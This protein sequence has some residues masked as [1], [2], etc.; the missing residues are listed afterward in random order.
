MMLSEEDGQH[1][2][3]LISIIVERDTEDLVV[4]V[5]A[6]EAQK[7]VAAE[8]ERIK[9]QA[10]HDARMEVV[11]RIKHERRLETLAKIKA[12]RER[13]KNA[14]LSKLMRESHARNRAKGKKTPVVKMREKAS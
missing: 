12:E 3:K 9:K 11:E 1:L 4:R 7:N 6:L 14:R 8:M 5:D 13:E 10:E 2:I